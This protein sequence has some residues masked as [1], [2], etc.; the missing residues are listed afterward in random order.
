MI[1]ANPGETVDENKRC[2]NQSPE[3]AHNDFGI[4]RDAALSRLRDDFLR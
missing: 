1:R 3:I 2:P 4:N